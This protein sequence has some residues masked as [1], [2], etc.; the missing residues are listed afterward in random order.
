M[1]KIIQL[2]QY[3]FFPHFSF[4]LILI[5]TSCANRE[6]NLSKTA[7]KSTQNIE[8][9]NSTN[10]V[11]NSENTVEAKA[12]TKVSDNTYS[13]STATDL[14]NFYKSNF[15]KSEEAN[16]SGKVTK[17]KKYYQ[18]GQVAEETETNEYLSAVKS[19]FQEAQEK[20]ENEKKATTYWQQN[21]DAA[22]SDFFKE[23]TKNSE[24]IKQNNSLKSEIYTEKKSKDLAVKKEQT[25]TLIMFFIGLILGWLLLPSLFKWIWS[26]IL[27]FN[28]Y[29]KAV[30]YINNFFK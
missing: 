9:I 6:K 28:P 24:L 8:A 22:K 17:T 1:R 19:A 12:S 15:A 11:K 5:L 3:W 2:I 13:F 20:Y 18:N 14:V 26:W 27:R 25:N 29:I 30:S 10:S 21:Y 7:E 4:C 23:Q 16:N